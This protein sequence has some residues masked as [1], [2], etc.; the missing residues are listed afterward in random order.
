MAYYVE[1]E[2][3][4]E[5]TESE[6]RHMALR[7]LQDGFGDQFIFRTEFKIK[8]P[9][10]N[11]RG[12]RLDLVVIDPATKRLV[13]ILEVKRRAYS[14]SWKQGARYSSLT[15]VPVIYLKGMIEA[16]C[17]VERVCKALS[18]EL[19]AGQAQPAGAGKVKVFR[20]ASLEHEKVALQAHERADRIQARRDSLLGGLGDSLFEI[21]DSPCAREEKPA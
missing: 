13:L 15:G 3:D 1:L 12:A 16:E 8:R 14:K 19:P 7:R 5:P 11:I 20:P 21:V 10:P 2:Q 9:A 17:A 18:I 4:S 6:C